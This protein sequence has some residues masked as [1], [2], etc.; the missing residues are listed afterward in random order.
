[1]LYL[2]RLLSPPAPKNN[3]VFRSINRRFIYSV[4]LL[5]FPVSIHATDKGIGIYFDQDL[6]TP[7]LNE[8]RDYTMGVAVELFEDRDQSVFDD[9]SC[10]I[11]RYLY[12]KCLDTG[13]RSLIMGSINYTPDNIGTYE[14]IQNDRPYASVFYM[15]Y[16]T[17][18]ADN[19]RAVG[20]ELQAGIIGLGLGSQVQEMIHELWRGTTGKNRPVDPNGWGHQISD[21]GEPTLRFRFTQQDILER[22]T[23]KWDLAWSRSA[24]IG[25]QTNVSAAITARYGDI[26]S[27]FWTIPFDPVNRGNFLPSTH[28]EEW[29]VWGAYR[30]RIVGYDALLQGQFRNSDVTFN[31]SEIRRLVHEGAIGITKAFKS[32]QLSFAMNAKSSELK[33][34]GADR[35]HY[36]GSFYVTLRY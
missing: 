15:G 8:D 10:K 20:T 29:Y 9:L 23:N 22:D 36:W 17:V 26:H 24:T 18:N 19:D 31:S 12:L 3:Q 16:K 30:M 14:A 34:G 25:Y 6:L 13:A 1:M 21:G 5:L 4:L 28:G 7:F 32:F 35:N 27:G 11:S 2:P 33:D